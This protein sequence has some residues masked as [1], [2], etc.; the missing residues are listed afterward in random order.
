MSNL[1]SYRST[2]TAAGDL[3]GFDV[4]A[5]DGHIGTVDET[6]TDASGSCLVVD[7]GFW[8]FGKKRLVPSGVVTQIDPAERKVYLSM[9]KD[10][11]KEAPDWQED[12]RT[13]RSARS[14]YDDYYSPYGW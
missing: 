2:L 9:T 14:Y 11:V 3:A 7:T 5:A 8:I 10:Q 4:E 12:W 13:N 1:W 6:N